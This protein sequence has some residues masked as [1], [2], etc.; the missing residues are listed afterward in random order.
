MLSPDHPKKQ[1][2]DSL[3]ASGH[4]GEIRALKDRIAELEEQ[5]SALKNQ[6]K[7]KTSTAKPVVA[8]TDRTFNVEEMEESADKEMKE[9]M[10]QLEREIANLKMEKEQ[11]ERIANYSTCN[12]VG[13][14][15]R[16]LAIKDD[17]LE[18]LGKQ[19][20]EFDAL[21]AKYL[22]KITDLTKERD[23]LRAQIDPSSVPVAPVVPVLTEALT[24]GVKM[25]SPDHPK[26]HQQDTLNVSYIF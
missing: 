11:L 7:S 15:K 10:E 25:L 14:L 2:Q 9:K 13:E 23:Q 5:N 3:N 26:K 16:Y 17:Q 24:Q 20:D 8:R 4:A 21:E 6:S 1:Q 22:Q 19:C 18:Y 12:E